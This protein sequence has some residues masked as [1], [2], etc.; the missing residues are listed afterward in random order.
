MSIG[1]V[2]H[3]DESTIFENHTGISL[4]DYRRLIVCLLIVSLYTITF[5]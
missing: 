4:L 5:I 1:S 2:E 3:D